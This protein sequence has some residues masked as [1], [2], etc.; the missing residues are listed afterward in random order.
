[1]TALLLLILALAAL[2]LPIPFYWTVRDTEAE[3]GWWARRTAEV[4]RVIGAERARAAGRPARRHP[5]REARA[6]LKEAA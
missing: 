2:T 5:Q 4:E 3:A 1:V 6:M